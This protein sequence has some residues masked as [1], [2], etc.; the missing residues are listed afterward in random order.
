MGKWGLFWPEPCHVVD[1]GLTKRLLEMLENKVQ[2]ATGSAGVSRLDRWVAELS[3]YRQSE[4]VAFPL[5]S[6]PH[7]FSDT[8]RMYGQEYPALLLQ[9]SNHVDT[10]LSLPCDVSADRGI[11]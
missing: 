5:G 10:Q 2:D 9:V 4:R 1:L 8:A 6:F 3:T 11:D 7:G